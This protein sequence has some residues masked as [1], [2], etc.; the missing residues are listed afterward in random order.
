MR[1]AIWTSLSHH[2]PDAVMMAIRRYNSPLRAWREYWGLTPWQVGE[3]LY[4]D[5]HPDIAA[6][7]VLDEEEVWCD[8]DQQQLRDWSEAL[9][10]PVDFLLPDFYLHV[11]GVKIRHP[12]GED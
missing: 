3:R 4:P 12:L 8:L 7:K 9:D 11:F 10:V 5:V 6:Q 1:S 2:V